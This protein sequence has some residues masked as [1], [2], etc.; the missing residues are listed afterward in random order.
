MMSPHPL[1]IHVW[2][3]TCNTCLSESGLFHL[4]WWFP[5]PPF[6][7]KWHDFT[8]LYGWI[9][10]HCVHI[11]HIFHIHSSADGCI[12]LKQGFRPQVQTPV[13]HISGLA[14]HPKLPNKQ[15][16]NGTGHRND[17]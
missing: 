16:S 8:L 9:I 7:C 14:T 13:F 12:G 10:L 1:H 15:T 6:S 3:K 17:I 2:E 4:T 5:I 11:Y